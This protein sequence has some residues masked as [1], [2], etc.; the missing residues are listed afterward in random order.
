MIFSHP[1]DF[2]KHYAKDLFDI[3][4]RCLR[5]P[6]LDAESASS[7]QAALDSLDN[8]ICG[9]ELGLPGPSIVSFE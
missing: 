4:G 7:S 6:G 9:K 8:P 5:D 2:Q 3:L 1:S